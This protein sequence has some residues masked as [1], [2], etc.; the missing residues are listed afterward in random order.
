M[1]LHLVVLAAAAV[2][3][4]A[5]AASAL[6][7]PQAPVQ[8]ATEDPAPD[9]P[10]P[11]PP[12]AGP[13]V[14]DALQRA[15]EPPPEPE[16]RIRTADRREVEANFDAFMLSLEALA[17]RDERLPR[18]RR[19]ELYRNANDLFAGLSA[20]LDPND[21]E[22]MQLLEDANIRMKAMLGELNISAV[23]PTPRPR[24]PR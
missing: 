3:A 1:K 21:A 2:A 19:E 4:S 15:L 5:W 6:R 18:T 7:G 24:S 22:D 13:T 8:A 14:A 20:T 12:K 11:L 17:D 10:P 9:V 16:P 23:A